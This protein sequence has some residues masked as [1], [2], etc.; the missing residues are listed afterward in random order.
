VRNADLTWP[1][2]VNQLRHRNGAAHLDLRLQ[3]MEKGV[4]GLNNLG[5]TCYMNSALQCISNTEPLTR[6]FIEKRH[7]TDLNK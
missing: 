6:Y 1:E 7:I 2:E 5:N 4:A 3:C